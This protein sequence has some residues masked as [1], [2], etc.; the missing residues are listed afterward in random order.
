MADKSH[1]LSRLQQGDP[2]AL[3]DLFQAYYTSLVQFSHQI[4]LK[5]AIAQDVVQ[6]V[7]VKLW[8]SR[9]TLDIRT[10]ISAYLFTAVRNQSINY[11]RSE[12]SREKREDKYALGIPFTENEVEE[13]IQFQEISNKLSEA[14]DKLPPR[15]KEIF[16]L[17]KM[18]GLTYKEVAA[19]LSISVKTVENQMGKALKFLREHLQDVLMGLVLIIEIL[20]KL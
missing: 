11:L 13:I 17:C 8:N 20:N 12:R 3:Q 19:K 16:I 2:K 18:E 6:E 7:F 10:S 14:I 15:C 9:K 5:E 1:I 4:V